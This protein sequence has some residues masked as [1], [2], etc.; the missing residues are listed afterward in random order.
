MD[1][2]K[3]TVTVSVDH[4]TMFGV[5]AVAKEAPKPP[6]ISFKDIAGQWVDGTVGRLA[7]WGSYPAS[8]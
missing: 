7:A 6:V 3:G 4:L 1:A 5:F 8:R 2:D